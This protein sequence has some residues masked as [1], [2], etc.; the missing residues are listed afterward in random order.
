MDR[1][2]LK[3]IELFHSRGQHL[4]KFIETKESVLHP[5]KFHYP[6]RIGL[7]HQYGRRFIILEHQYDRRNVMCK[8]SIQSRSCCSLEALTAFVS[9]VQHKTQIR[10]KTTVG[11]LY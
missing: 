11:F 3:R 5:K 6:H 2:E 1:K 7:K 9:H 8:A 4:C 10:E